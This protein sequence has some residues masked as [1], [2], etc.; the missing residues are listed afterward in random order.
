[1]TGSNQPTARDTKTSYVYREGELDYDEHA[2]RLI[3][4]VLDGRERDYL[5]V[6]SVEAQTHYSSM[7]RELRWQPEN[8]ISVAKALRKRLGTKRKARRTIGQWEVLSFRFDR[9]CCANTNYDA[10]DQ[11]QPGT[12]TAMTQDKLGT[13]AEPARNPSATSPQ[14]KGL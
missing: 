9:A 10:M 5:N 6:T 2:V 13:S 14:R 8:W 11:H 12:R 1:M 7:C 4:W 3:V